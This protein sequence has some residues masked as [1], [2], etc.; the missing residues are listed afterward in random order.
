MAIVLVLLLGAAAGFTFRVT[1]EGEGGAIPAVSHPVDESNAD[2]TS[3]HAL[4]AE[5]EEGM[6]RSHRN[7]GVP[8]CLTCHPVRPE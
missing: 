5:G 4:A 8:T 1:A 3:C 7:Y 2:C 6:P